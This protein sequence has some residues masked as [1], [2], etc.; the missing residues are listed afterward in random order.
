MEALRRRLPDQADK[1]KRQQD[2]LTGE[3][4]MGLLFKVMGIST[5]GWPTEAPGF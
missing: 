1:L 5:P 4:Q 2:R 3:S